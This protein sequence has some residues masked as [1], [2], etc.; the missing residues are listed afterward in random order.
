LAIFFDLV[1]PLIIAAPFIIWFQFGFAEFLSVVIPFIFA[2]FWCKFSKLAFSKN[3]YESTPE[4]FIGYSPQIFLLG[5]LSLQVV[6]IPLYAFGLNVEVK[7]PT[8]IGNWIS[9]VGGGL[10]L[11]LAIVSAII[12]WKKKKKLSPE[13]REGL[14]KPSVWVYIF[15]LL[16]TGFLYNNFTYTYGVPATILY[17]LNGFFLT[18]L[19]IRFVGFIKRKIHPSKKIQGI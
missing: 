13:Q 8:I 16:F 4:D 15:G 17:W 9:S 5:A 18:V 6:A 11:F 14:Y 1:A 2:L 3:Y 19:I 12:W 10:F 7:V